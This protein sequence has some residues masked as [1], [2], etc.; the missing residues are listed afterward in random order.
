[1][2]SLSR[3]LQE[4]YER[5]NNHF[6]PLHWWPAE[7][8]FE[9]VVGAVLTQNT[10]WKNVEK[11]ID[12]LKRAGVFSFD[13][14]QSLTEEELAGHI[15]SSGY[16]NLKARRLKNLLEM[17]IRDFG[18][19][20][21]R[22]FAE[23]TVTARRALLEVKG[24]GPETADSILLYGGGHPVFVVDAYTH[25]ILSRHN[26]IAEECDYQ[27]IQDLFMDNLNNDAEMFN[28][29]HALLVITAKHFCKKRNPLCS[30]CPLEPML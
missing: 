18:G 26:L 8:P 21:E 1:M 2:G 5:L 24:I 22:L 6:G 14:L 30:R 17:I 10:N 16:Y 25:R 15:R 7:N 23:N 29:Y 13:G 19:D 4:A 28:Q 27:L 12:S 9:V 3:T 11:A 20:L